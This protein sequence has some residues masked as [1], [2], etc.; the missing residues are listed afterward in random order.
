[1]STDDEDS[2]KYH[3][4]IE[5]CH[6]T[7]KYRGAAHSI[8]NLRYKTPKEIIV[9]FH[10]VSTY[11]YY[12]VIKEL[13]KEFE[14][15]FE[16][17]GEN[18]EKY[19]SFS[20]PIKKQL[21]NSKTITYKKRFFDSFRFMSTL[22]SKLVNTLSEI[23]IKKWRDKNCK[24]ECEFKYCKNKKPSYRCSECKKKR[25]KPINELIKKFSNTYKFCNNDIN[26]FILLLKKVLIHMNTWIVGKDLMKLH[27]QMKKLLQ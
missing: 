23:Y 14:G 18:T 16:S 7:W 24:S 26:K 20:V 5:Y 6:Y 12:F 15:Q 3:K 21:D 13:L 1:M 19:I 25:L 17:L 8:C 22:L 9:V 4:V 2:E 10:K 11:D 27:F